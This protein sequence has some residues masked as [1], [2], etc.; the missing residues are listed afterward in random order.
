MQQLQALQDNCTPQ[1]TRLKN[2][3][4]SFVNSGIKNKI[5]QNIITKEITHISKQIELL[6]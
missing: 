1:L 4:E 6:D 2:Q 5:A 3:R